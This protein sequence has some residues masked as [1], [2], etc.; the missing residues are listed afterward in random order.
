MAWQCRQ[1]EKEAEETWHVSSE[2]WAWHQSCCSCVLLCVIKLCQPDCKCT[3][4]P[5]WEHLQR[6]ERTRKAV[7]PEAF[8]HGSLNRIIAGGKKAD[9]KMHY[10]VLR[11]NKTQFKSLCGA[12]LEFACPPRVCLG[13]PASSHRVKHVGEG[14]IIKAKSSWPSLWRS[15]WMC[16]FVL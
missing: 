7:R 8:F 16:L 2:V 5:F 13:S 12:S 9:L 6:T 11:Q 1:Q 3:L 14:W 10:Y 4:A 15:A